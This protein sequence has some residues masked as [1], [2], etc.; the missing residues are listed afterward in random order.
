[1]LCVH[2]LVLIRICIANLC[3]FVD[4]TSRRE[5]IRENLDKEVEDFLDR[6][7]HNLT[8]GKKKSQFFCLTHSNDGK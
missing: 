3:V 8:K 4:V 6:V 1:M 5:K 2:A 7:T